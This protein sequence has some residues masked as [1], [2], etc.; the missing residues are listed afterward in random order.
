MDQD[1][2]LEISKLDINS[3]DGLK[4]K[5]QPGTSQEY[6]YQICKSLKDTL[7]EQGK[8]VLVF[9]MTD[10]S[11]IETIPREKIPEIIEKLNK[12]LQETEKEEK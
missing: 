9:S 12:F 7:K 8:E 3:G 4:V 6:R 1:K 11:E 5:F 2:I 10:E